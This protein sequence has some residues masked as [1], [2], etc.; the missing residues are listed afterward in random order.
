MSDDLNMLTPLE[1]F[2][3]LAITG[4]DAAKFFQ[5]YATCD[6]DLANGNASLVGAICTIQGRMLCNFRLIPTETGLLL[7]MPRALIAPAIEFLSKYIVFSKASLEDLSDNMWC[8]GLTQN[9]GNVPTQ[10]DTFAVRNEQEADN[11]PIEVVGSALDGWIIK[12][13]IKTDDDH[14]EIWSNKP[15]LADQP[16]SH[17]LELEVRAGIAWV[18]TQTTETFI[19]QMFNL[20]SLNG[21][22][23]E[24]GCYL[25]QEIVA[26]MQFRGELKK[27]L[28]LCSVH[29]NSAHTLELGQDIQNE[30]GKN[31]GQVVA[32]G[33]DSFLSVIQTKSPKVAEQATPQPSTTYQLSNGEPI[34]IKD[35]YLSD[36]E[37]QNDIAGK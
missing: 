8:Y 29:S 23:F 11:D 18:A 14:F 27:R 26:R 30:M 6:V 31:V 36:P 13:D 19:P 34:E 5:G 16:T 21:I 12:V 9:S 1:H 32:V 7:R 20:Q 10:S 24:K 35:L 17:W 2:G 22:S 33:T 25:G 28:H 37:K 3:F 4:K 15:L